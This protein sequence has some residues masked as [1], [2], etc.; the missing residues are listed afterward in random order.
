MQNQQSDNIKDAL[1]FAGGM[2]DRE[3]ERIK[4]LHEDTLKSLG[5][6]VAAVLL[7][8]SLLGWIGYTNLRDAAVESAQ[9]TVQAEVTRQVQEKLTKEHIDEIVKDQVS[10]YSKATME[11][12]IQK[13]LQTEP[14]ASQIR[15]A[16]SS[17][18]SNIV[19]TKF[20]PR[21]ITSDQCSAFVKAVDSYEDLNGFPVAVIPTAFNTEADAF[22]SEIEKCIKRTSLNLIAQGPTV[23]APNV[24]GV[25]LYRDEQGPTEPAEHLQSAFAAIGIKTKIVAGHPF[26][27]VE[28]GEK[29]PINIWVGTKEIK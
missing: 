8:F 29:F 1:E 2:A 4:S 27:P 10:N 5:I 22:S 21:H 9:K 6:L 20:Q 23:Q 25:G 17:T 3:I 24:D 14:L 26:S 15:N 11:A 7:V 18:A 19:A 13:D 16:A 28:K 12:A